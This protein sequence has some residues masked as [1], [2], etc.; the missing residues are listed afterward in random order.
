MSQI[1]VVDICSV[2]TKNKNADNKKKR[3][4]LIGGK[5]EENIFPYNL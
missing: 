3:E 5:K 1:K 4:G 2:D